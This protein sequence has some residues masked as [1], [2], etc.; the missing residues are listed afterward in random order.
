MTRCVA[1]GWIAAAIACTDPVHQERVAALGEE[2]AG[3]PPGPLHRPGQPCLVC[4]GPEGPAETEY[5]IA[6]TV[7]RSPSDPGPVE[8]AEIVVRDAN[9]ARHRALTNAA[10]NF[11]IDA[12][13]APRFPVYVEVQNNDVITHMT[14]PI[15]RDGSC[16]S[17]HAEGGDQAHMP[18]VYA[19]P[20]AP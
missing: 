5:A 3:T 18:R 15:N 17:C 14:T 16:A 13:D 12:S 2:A 9:G 1:L 10:G 6:G 7:Y 19:E 4:H 11:T 8:G 20:D